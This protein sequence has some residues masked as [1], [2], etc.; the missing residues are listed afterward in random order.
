MSYFPRPTRRPITHHFLPA[1]ANQENSINSSS[2][3]SHNIIILIRLAYI[4]SGL[5]LNTYT[6]LLF[7]A[8][9]SL[10][11][12]RLLNTNFKLF[13][14]ATGPI[15]YAE[16]QTSLS[17]LVSWTPIL[18]NLVSPSVLAPFHRAVSAGKVSILPETDDIELVTKFDHKLLEDRGFPH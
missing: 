7:S 11:S 9:H 3:L 1:A 16:I 13:S 12:R 10:L 15:L 14:I 18:P 6:F 8:L 17:T 5:W 4:N 2:S